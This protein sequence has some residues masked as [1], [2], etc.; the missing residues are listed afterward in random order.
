MKAG[1]ILHRLRRARTLIIF[2]VVGAPFLGSCRRADQEGQAREF[3]AGWEIRFNSHDLKTFC[4]LYAAGNYT[5]P[6]MIGYSRDP[7][8][9]CGVLDKIW[10]TSPDMRLRAD[11]DFIVAS[12]DR[13]A[14][15]FELTYTPPLQR[16]AVVQRG[17]TFLQLAEGKIRSQLTVVGAP[18]PRN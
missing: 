5:V 6:G 10:R 18:A 13:L 3:I 14:F 16:T 2:L 4:P 12:D 7:Q 9:L 17:A 8:E 1:L 15:L 11:K